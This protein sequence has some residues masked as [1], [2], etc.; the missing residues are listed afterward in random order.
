MLFYIPYKICK[1]TLLS[2]DF[3][4][5]V[6]ELFDNPSYL[7]L[8]TFI[9]R[10]FNPVVQANLTILNVQESDFD[11]IFSCWIASDYD[12][13]TPKF[14]VR[15][16]QEGTGVDLHVFMFLDKLLII[17]CTIMFTSP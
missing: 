16:R 14:H 11:V 2:I 3:I 7:L 12:I 8:F 6:Y 5:S 1:H 15:L 4:V 10:E 9:S 17:V 13:E